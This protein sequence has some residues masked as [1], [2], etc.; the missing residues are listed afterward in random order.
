MVLKQRELCCDSITKGTDIEFKV[1]GTGGG[2][3]STGPRTPTTPP[4][5]WGGLWPAFS[6]QRCRPQESR[7]A[8]GARHSI[9]TKA[10]RRKL[11]STLHPNTILKPNPDPK[12]HPNPQPRPNPTPTPSPAPS[13]NPNQD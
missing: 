6:R 2:G 7:G 3:D 1:W 4:P 10:T 8:K 5:P 9:S 11:L 13:P 12:T